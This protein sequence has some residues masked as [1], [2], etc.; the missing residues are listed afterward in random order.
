M[1]KE[2]NEICEEDYGPQYLKKIWS[3]IIPQT[4]KLQKQTNPDTVTADTTHKIIVRYGSG[5]N[6]TDD[7]W[8]MYFENKADSD[9]YAKDQNAK[10]GHRFDINYILDPYFAHKTLEIFCTEKIE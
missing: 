7:M 10:V 3:S 5:K 6:I 1:R 4:G 8:L 9:I 2:E